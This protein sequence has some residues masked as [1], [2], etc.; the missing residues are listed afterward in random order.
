MGKIFLNPVS[1]QAAMKGKTPLEFWSV[2]GVNVGSAS[3]EL[4]LK[5]K[6]C[7]QFWLTR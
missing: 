4:F 5:F 7:E 2:A 1:V 3:C 6:I